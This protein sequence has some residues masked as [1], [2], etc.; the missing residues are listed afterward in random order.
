MSTAL[1][2]IFLSTDYVQL[3]AH[4]CFAI[5]YS[6]ELVLQAAFLSFGGSSAN[7]YVAD[8]FQEMQMPIFGQQQQHQV[9]GLEHRV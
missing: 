1:D 3:S 2:L 5:A 6:T 9:S 7:N 4:E 8:P